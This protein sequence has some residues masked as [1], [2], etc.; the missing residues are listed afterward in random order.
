MPIVDG[1]R[2]ANTAGPWSHRHFQNLLDRQMRPGSPGC[3]LYRFWN[4]ETALLL[5]VGVTRNPP[6]R[7]DAHR[8]KA[9]W[10]SEVDVIGYVLYRDRYAAL[11]AEVSAIR[12]EC[13][14]YNIRTGMGA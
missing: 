10:W 5:Y 4:A 9:P 6:N 2:Y 12:S 7:W 1:I 3:F 8:W 14:L 13:P 11:R